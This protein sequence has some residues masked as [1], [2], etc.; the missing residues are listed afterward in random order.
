[1]RFEQ[2]SELFRRRVDYG[3]CFYFVVV[4]HVIHVVFLRA[5]Q[6]NAAPFSTSLR[7]I[8]RPR[9]ST[10]SPSLFRLCVVSSATLR[11]FGLEIAT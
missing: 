2:A 10:A 5:F 3:L 4:V 7:P 9:L 1:M 11:R 8:N 6:K